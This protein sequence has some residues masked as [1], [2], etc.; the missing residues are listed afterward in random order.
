MNKRIGYAVRNNHDNDYVR[1]Q[2]KD[3]VVFAS[4]EDANTLMEQQKWNP[5]DYTIEKLVKWRKPRAKR[6]QTL[7]G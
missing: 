2:Y 5:S 4:I 1:D 3:I 7:R 6:S